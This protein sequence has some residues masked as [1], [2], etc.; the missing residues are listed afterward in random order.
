M[1]NEWLSANKLTLNINN[2]KYVIFG[3]P[4]KLTQTPH[5]NLTINNEPISRVS[6]MKYLGITLD[7]HLNFNKH[8]E[9]IHAKAVNK[10]GL[11][12]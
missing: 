11:L 12:R 10:L 5:F 8:T 4:N 1:V 6:E 7:E 9:I 2:T 3:K